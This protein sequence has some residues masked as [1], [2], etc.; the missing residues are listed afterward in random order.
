MTKTEDAQISSRT[1]AGVKKWPATQKPDENS[2]STG[3]ELVRS[4]QGKAVVKHKI[5]LARKKITDNA[6]AIHA[7][8]VPRA[9]STTTLV[10]RRT[11]QVT[12]HLRRFNKRH[13]GPSLSMAFKW[14][15][16]RIDPR[17][18][19][20]DYR[21]FLRIMH[22]V[23]WDRSE[24]SLFFVRTRG[25]V[26]TVRLS[27]PSLAREEAQDYRPTPV[28]VFHWAM[29][30]L[31]EDLQDTA[32]VDFGAGRGRVLLLAS[33]YPFEK[34]IGAEIAVELH[35]DCRMNIAQYPRSLMSC[36]AV[37]CLHTNATSLPL[38]DQPAVFYFFNPFSAAVFENVLD[39]ITR[40]YKRRRRQMH[41]I[42][43]DMEE[44]KA[45]ATSGIFHPV[46][47]PARQRLRTAVLSPYSLRVYKSEP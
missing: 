24:D 8:A 40:S 39:R 45:I 22:A 13:T 44:R 31:P 27:I 17:S 41:L 20:R 15:L 4:R 7:S 43:V 25:T 46:R 34:I 3:K 1:D 42:C 32:F 2:S 11:T 19:G 9:A 29:S 21:R 35:D 38:P 16:R 23:L 47:L 26:S 14:L 5:S 12:L 33:H 10:R 30:A 18:I 28:S 6:R 36:R 37:D